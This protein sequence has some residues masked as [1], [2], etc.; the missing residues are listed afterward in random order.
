MTMTKKKKRIL[1]IGIPAAV[2]VIAA[3]IV[4]ILLLRPREEAPA[5]R[6]ARVDG[7][8]GYAS[9]MITY[10]VLDG[11]ENV[12]EVSL[13]LPFYGYDAPE[14]YVHVENAEQSAN[15]F[16]T[17]YEDVYRP[18]ED[19]NA[20]GATITFHQQLAY[21]GTVVAFNSNAYPQE[22]Q[23]GDLTVIYSIDPDGYGANAYWL[24]D[25]SL[26]EISY[27]GY[28]SENA[29]LDLVHRVNYQQQRQP[30]YSPLEV[31]RG[32]WIVEETEN[33]IEHTRSNFAS[34]GNPEIPSTIRLFDFEQPPEGF[35][36]YQMVTD[37]DEDSR[38][39][40]EL[41][42]LTF[43]YRNG[44]D[45]RL[46]IQNIPGPAA[47]L[48]ISD[49]EMND[50]QIIAQVLD[51]TVNGNPGFFYQRR[52]QTQLSWITDYLTIVMTYEGD[53]TQEEMIALAESLVQKEPQT[54]S[55]ASASSN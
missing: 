40:M 41:R 37:D 34:T 45:E 1:L 6:L 25:H 46:F 22:V 4:C 43:R 54:Q 3:V 33:A 17:S 12:D 15:R 26:L 16:S 23:F 55:E 51:V 36:A 32:G 11:I 24:Y 20:Y 35:S 19:D 27:S 8:D 39:P 30:E 13:P 7:V 18:T 52:N 50:E 2:V 14:G 21:G 10:T 44:E 49:T 53:I 47:M 5:M 9:S 29:L 48:S 42:S 28:L 31:Q 38:T